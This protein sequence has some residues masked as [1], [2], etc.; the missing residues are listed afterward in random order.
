MAHWKQGG[1]EALVCKN[2]SV[3]PVHM[4]PQVLPYTR[5]D[6]KKAF[7]AGDAIDYDK[8]IELIKQVGG[9]TLNL[10]LALL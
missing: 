10:Y 7:K 4:A 1:E 8:A 3:V 6:C 5:A 9:S 2:C